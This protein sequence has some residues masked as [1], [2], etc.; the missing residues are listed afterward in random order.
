MMMTTPLSP[1]CRPRHR[2]RAAVALVRGLV[3][4]DDNNDDDDAAFVPPCRLHH[5]RRAAAALVRGL[6]VALA[7]SLAR[8]V[9][10]IVLALAQN[11]F[12]DYDD[13]DDDD[14]AFVSPCRLRHYRRA[15]AALVRGLVVALAPSL[16]RALARGVVVIVLALKPNLF[17]DD[18][19]D[20]DDNAFVSPLPPAPSLQKR[21][22]LSTGE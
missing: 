11:L 19:N 8:G 22:S 12:D 7:R 1:P 14:D 6:A 18:D 9:F 21:W 13:N 10:F 2:R 4:D 20:D 15:A 17:D 3:V 16:A 5:R